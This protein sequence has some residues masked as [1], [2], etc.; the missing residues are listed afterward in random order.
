VLQLHEPG[1]H[2]L[3]CGPLALFIFP[4]SASK[5]VGSP[6]TDVPLPNASLESKNTLLFYLFFTSGGF[7]S[8][9]R[10][11]I[12]P[13]FFFFPLSHKDETTTRSGAKRLPSLF[14]VSAWPFPSA[15]I[16]GPGSFFSLPPHSCFSPPFPIV[17]KA[18]NRSNSLPTKCH[19]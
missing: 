9:Y 6:S 12:N 17:S 18:Q 15:T 2:F 11:I 7:S 13:F 16:Q 1:L 8:K 4:F 19:L 14:A 3:P 5:K 10:Q